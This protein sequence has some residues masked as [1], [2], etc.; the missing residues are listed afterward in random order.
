MAGIN[1][2]ELQRADYNEFETMPVRVELHR[3]VLC[4]LNKDKHDRG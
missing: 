3:L 1:E 2:S 4:N